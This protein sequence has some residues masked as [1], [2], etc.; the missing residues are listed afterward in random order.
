MKKYFLIGISGISMS[1]IAVMLKSE[2]NEVKG[3]DQNPCAELEN[4][5]ITVELQPNFESILWAD[6][7]VYSSAFSMDF[8][9]LNYALICRK[10]IT[11]RGEKL[12]EIAS[13]YE[14][15]VAV[16]GSHGKSTTTAMIYNIL[17]VAG[18]MPTLHLGAKLQENGKNF[19]IAGQEYFVTE[20][21]E[22]HDNFLFLQPYFSVVTNI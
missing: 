14:K 2:G 10:K 17:R 12:G 5:G 20:A 8:P 15:V 6:E 16:A 11:V 4:E 3:Y 9:L 22:Y 13:H 1:A 7:I 21:C 19:D 18:K